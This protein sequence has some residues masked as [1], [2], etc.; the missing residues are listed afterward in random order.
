MHEN[1]LDI[2]ALIK[3]NEDRMGNHG[4]MGRRPPPPKRIIKTKEMIDREK[5]LE[6]KANYKLKEL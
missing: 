5:E 4:D 3:S 6:A 2:K 1:R